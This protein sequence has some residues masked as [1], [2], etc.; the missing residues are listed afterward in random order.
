MIPSAVATTNILSSILL[1]CVTAALT[2]SYPWYKFTD[3]SAIPEAFQSTGVNGSYFVFSIGGLLGLTT[4]LINALHGVTRI[5]FA[6]KTDRLLC[7][8]CLPKLESGQSFITLA[9]LPL[10][11]SSL[12]SLICTLNMLIQILALGTLI[13]HSCVAICVIN[14]R[15]QSANVGLI[16][17]YE[18]ITDDQQ[19][20]EFLYAPFLTYNNNICDP[21]ANSGMFERVSNDP[22]YQFSIAKPRNSTYQKMDSIV[23]ASPVGSTNSLIELPI[24]VSMEPT[25]STSMT[26]A[27]SLIIFILGSTMFSFVVVFGNNAM[28]DG[29]W[30]ACACFLIS[31]IILI[32]TTAFIVKQPTNQSKLLFK[33]PY[34]PF[35]PLLSIFLNM[36]LMSALS[37]KAWLRFSV[38]LFVGEFNTLIP[39]SLL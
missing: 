4:A 1:V 29:S 3:H 15:Y 36:M 16:K 5:V 34:V 30:W 12:F 37:Y 24:N 35:V 10:L 25:N 27:V 13:A 23:N 9:L 26:A 17:E 7:Q 28:A 32:V 14:V 22:K 38:W 31:V 20:T 2:L 21:T 19:S 18:D 11:L 6:M 33:A 8:C 39:R